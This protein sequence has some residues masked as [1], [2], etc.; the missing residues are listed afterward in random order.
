VL[1][2]VGEPPLDPDRREAYLDRMTVSWM[3]VPQ[4]RV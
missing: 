1:H 2:T 3:T 4:G